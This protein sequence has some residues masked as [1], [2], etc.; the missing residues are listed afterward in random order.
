MDITVKQLSVSVGGENIFL[1]I[2]LEM[3]ISLVNLPLL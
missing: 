3:V 1:R 2:I